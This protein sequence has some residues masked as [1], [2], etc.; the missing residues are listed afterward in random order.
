MESPRMRP[1]RIKPDVR[2]RIDAATLLFP[3][4]GIEANATI[5]S[6]PAARGRNAIQSGRSE[7]SPAQ[8]TTAGQLCSDVKKCFD[9]V[10]RPGRQVL[11]AQRSATSPNGGQE[12]WRACCRE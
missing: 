9:Q 11:R 2:D 10:T 4:S 6:L 8:Q 1:S 3:P 7:T 5:F 12:T